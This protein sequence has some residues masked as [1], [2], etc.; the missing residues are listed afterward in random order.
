MNTNF[1]S[2][3]LMLQLFKREPYKQLQQHGY[4][5]MN[6]IHS[7]YNRRD[8][9]TN[10]IHKI[11]D[12]NPTIKNTC[13]AQV[14]DG[15]VQDTLLEKISD[16]K[17]S[18]NKFDI[19]L[20]RKKQTEE[21]IGML[22]VETGECQH[23]ILK[24]SPVL[25]LICA[26]SGFGPY[27]I[28]T[29]LMAMLYNFKTSRKI[30]AYVYRYGVLELAGVYDNIEGLCAYNKFGFRE[31]YRIIQSD[32]FGSPGTLPMTVD[33]GQLTET[34]LDNVILK[35]KV[36]NPNQNAES[37][38][39]KSYLVN[40]Y[41]KKLQLK[42]QY[43]RMNK[44]NQLLSSDTEY[45]DRFLIQLDQNAYDMLAKSKYMSSHN[46]H[47]MKQKL[48]QSISLGKKNSIRNKSNRMFSYKT[49]KTMK[50]KSKSKSKSMTKSKSKS[51]STI[52]SKNN[53][54]K[55]K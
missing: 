29:Y 27:L 20:L 23:R 33:V 13:T 54:I 10:I 48:L 6:D 40:P 38:C 39:D 3:E 37:L 2:N 47:K 50:L 24:E 49:R 16:L 26:P 51:K 21:N 19:L 14:N 7:L 8:S 53:Q 5:I 28:Y 55:V 43:N 34:M 52:K 32:C 35:K 17:S 42:E 12:S 11:F 31:N 15:Y 30:N 22:I 41:T 36:I 25:R 9:V 46:L 45:N 4:Y 44:Y 1:F 18:N